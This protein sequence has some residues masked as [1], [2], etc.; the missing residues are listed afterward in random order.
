MQTALAAKAGSDIV[1]FG[2]NEQNLES[3]N[4]LMCEGRDLPWLQDIA[5]VNA[6]EAWEVTFRDVV[7]LD[8]DNVRVAAFN[9]TT[10]DLAVP[11]NYDSLETLLLETAGAR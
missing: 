9:L 6:W 7:I 11:A 1:I 3:G 4:D 2:V 8:E 10:Y 5:G